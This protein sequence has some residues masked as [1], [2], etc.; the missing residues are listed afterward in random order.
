MAAPGSGPI[1][2]QAGS[3]A[4]LAL[5][6]AGCAATTP[7]PPTPEEHLVVLN[8]GDAS[9]TILPL[10]SPTS[11]VTVHLGPI[12]G[13]PFALAARGSRGLVTSGAGSTV[14]LVDLGA[15]QSVLVYGLA[16][17]AGATGVAF[18]NDSIAYIANPFVNRVT[19]LNIRQGDTISI[20]VGQTPSAIA[21]TRGRVF[22][23]NANL[24]PA[25]PAQA[26]CV[27]GPSWLTVI[28][29]DREIVV[30]SIA[31]PGP[32]NATSITVGGDG[33]LYVISAG[34]GGEEAGRLSIVDPVLRQEVG[35]FAGFG[36]LPGQVSS[37]GRER[38]FVTSE[39][40]GLM[41]FNT[42]TRRLVRGAGSGIPL[43]SGVDAAV[44]SDGLVYAV[45]SGNCVSSPGRIRIFR[46]DLTEVRIILVGICAVDAD[47]V[48]LLPNS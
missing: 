31:L 35:S 6:L 45:E 26:P 11:P 38:L 30:D 33:L 32:G 4:L 18:V 15:P 2:R 44:G 34:P 41:E 29:P 21:V 12:G 25:C 36:P 43:Q 16:A 37:D 48:R 28:D 23:A 10:S 20:A 24:D 39:E 9:I 8:A 1:V 7:S 22:V 47:I 17:G 27:L 13:T 14:A 5:L 42:R 40:H 19:R 46:P 3:A